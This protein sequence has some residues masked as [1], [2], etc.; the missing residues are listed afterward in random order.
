MRTVSRFDSEPVVGE[1]VSGTSEGPDV[2][3]SHWRG[4]Y[5]GVRPSEWDGEPVHVFTDGDINGTPQTCFTLPVDRFDEGDEPTTVYVSGDWEWDFTLDVY[6]TAYAAV[7]LGDPWNGFAT[8][9]VS[10]QVMAA[11][12]AR[13]EFLAA[14]DPD[15]YGPTSLRWDGNGVAITDPDG[16]ETSWLLPD[17]DG[18][19]DLAPLGW[20]WSTLGDAEDDHVIRRVG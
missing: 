19:F 20:T 18:N 2:G 16:E 15:T 5:Q 13:Q 6:E 7:R 12:V 11:I 10:H 8:P 3:I 14:A 1:R 4:V 17:A 9:V